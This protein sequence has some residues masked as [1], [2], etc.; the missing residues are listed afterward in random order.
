MQIST[1]NLKQLSVRDCSTCT[2]AFKDNL[3]LLQFGTKERRLLEKPSATL[4]HDGFIK[5]RPS[6]DFHKFE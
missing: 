6:I 1:L 4:Q 5:F 3:L 2:P